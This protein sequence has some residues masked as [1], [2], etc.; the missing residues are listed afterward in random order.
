MAEETKAGEPLPMEVD[1][2]GAAPSEAK[3]GDASSSKAG[4]G[5]DSDVELSG[6]EESEGEDDDA[7]AKDDSSDPRSSPVPTAAAGAAA[8]AGG[9]GEVHDYDE[10]VKDHEERLHQLR[11]QAESKGRPTQ[12]LDPQARIQYL[13]QQSEVFTNFL[14]STDFGNKKDTG[15]AKGK[16]KKGGG[17]GRTRMQEEEE[18]KLMMKSALSKAR[19]TRV[20][21]QPSIIRHG[22]MRSYQLE[23]LNWMIKLHDNG[24]NGI[25]ADEMGLGKTLQ[26]IS[27]L[28]YL[29]EA[30]GINGP[31]IVIVPKSTV[32]NWLREFGRWCPTIKAV[33]LLGNRDERTAVV[34]NVIEPR[35]FDVIVTSYECMLKEQQHL[36][37]VQWR[38]LMIDEAHRIKNENSSLSKVVRTMSTQF[39]LL[40]TGTPLQNN[41]HELWALLN[42][43]LPDVFSR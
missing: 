38:Y 34:H 14:E 24:I 30:R 15:A 17:G 37:K 27:L 36:R 11:L 13:M 41:L 7:D 1:G 28:A 32:G 23:G 9:G 2:D 21:Q 29:R 6:I 10:V 16:G 20:L 42:F 43:L 26:S 4:N 5:E 12:G 3:G 22:T 35:A 31:H 8:A 25:L 39:R 40:I 19:V 33:R 18:D